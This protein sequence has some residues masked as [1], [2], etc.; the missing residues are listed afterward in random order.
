MLVGHTHWIKK[1]LRLPNKPNVVSPFIMSYINMRLKFYN[2]VIASL[3]LWSVIAIQF[4][5]SRIQTISL[6]KQHQRSFHHHLTPVLTEC[7]NTMKSFTILTLY[8][9]C[10]VLPN[11]L[12]CAIRCRSTAPARWPHQANCSDASSATFDWAAGYWNPSPAAQPS[13]R[14]PRRLGQ[15]QAAERQPNQS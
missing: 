8:W 4:S 1:A 5:F 11:V 7:C 10:T 3:Q 9:G 6:T 2:Q 13:W 14:H 15:Q 12:R